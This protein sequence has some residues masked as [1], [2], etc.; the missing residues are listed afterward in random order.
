MTENL[1]MFG[2]YYVLGKESIKQDMSW[3]IHR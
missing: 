2:F 1:N 3:A